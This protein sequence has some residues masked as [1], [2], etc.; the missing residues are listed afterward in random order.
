MLYPGG[1][2]Y[3]IVLGGYAADNLVENN[4]SWNFNKVMVMRTTGGGNVIAYNY[5]EDGYGAGYPTIVETGL[6]ASHMTT[7]HMELFEGNQSFNFDSDSTWGNSIY[8][9]VFRN[10]LTGK[11]RSIPPVS[12][13]DQSNR[14]AVGLTLDHWWYS[15][16]G[17]V[18][19]SPGQTANPAPGFVYEMTANYGSDSRVP[20]WKL[21]YDGENWG[22]VQDA[23][24]ASTTL[25]HGNFDYVTNQIAWDPAITRTEL[26]PSLYLTKKP[27]FFGSRRWPWVAPEDAADPIG[28]LPAR[29][30]FDMLH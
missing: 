25:R 22:P 28:T 5:M 29:E 30:R 10:H 26:P 12:V 11:R 19:G 14:R 13:S 18:L 9:T 3:G 4:I 20:M 27:A 2:G 24:V 16:V 15:F 7:P 8:I 23:K 6:N 1:A 17:N 21:G